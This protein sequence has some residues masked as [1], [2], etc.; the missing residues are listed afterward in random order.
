MTSHGQSLKEIMQINVK[1]L[2]RR[3]LELSVVID[4]AVYRTLGKKLECRSLELSVIID[5][6]VYRTPGKKLECRSLELSDILYNAVYTEGKGGH[7][8]F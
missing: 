5:N 3:Y 1:E 4:N 8:Y 2:E 7:E 6:A